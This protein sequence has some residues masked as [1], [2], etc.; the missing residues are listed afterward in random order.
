MVIF[1][2]DS[3]KKKNRFQPVLFFILGID[4]VGVMWYTMGKKGGNTHE[5]N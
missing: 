3:Q 2:R 4:K 5:K 1:G